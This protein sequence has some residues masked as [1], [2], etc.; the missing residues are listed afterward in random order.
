MKWHQMALLI[1]GSFDLEFKER[2]VKESPL[3]RLAGTGWEP[4]PTTES[5]PAVRACRC[6]HNNLF[7]FQSKPPSTSFILRSLVPPTCLRAQLLPNGFSKTRTGGTA[8]FMGFLPFFPLYCCEEF[9]PDEG[10][11][12][13]SGNHLERGFTKLTAELHRFE[14]RSTGDEQRL[15]PS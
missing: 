4:G 9:F 12:G 8:G 6:L 13:I 10:F 11:Y 7:T 15:R 3:Q 2:V 1:E 5:I 14:A